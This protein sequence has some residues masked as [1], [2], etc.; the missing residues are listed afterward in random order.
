MEECHQNFVV[1]S[2]IYLLLTYYSA[3]LQ[4]VEK[5]VDVVTYIHQAII[6]AFGNN[7]TKISSNRFLKEIILCT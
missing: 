7:G 2:P 3:T 4:I 5:L 1:K 6:E